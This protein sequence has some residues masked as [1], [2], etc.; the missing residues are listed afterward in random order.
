MMALQVKKTTV[1]EVKITK[2]FSVIFNCTP[3]VS[4][5]EQMSTEG[6]RKLY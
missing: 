5:Q 4:H 1:D 2:Y 3:D 6:N